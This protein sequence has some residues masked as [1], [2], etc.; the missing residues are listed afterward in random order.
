MEQHT[1]ITKAMSLRPLILISLMGILLIVAQILFVLNFEIPGSRYD[2]LIH[3]AIISIYLLFWIYTFL[4]IRNASKDLEKESDRYMD[5]ILKTQ[6][7]I[8][9]AEVA[10][11]EKIKEVR[12]LITASH[13]FY[14][15]V[16]DMSFDEWWAMLN[17][18]VMT[19]N[20]ERRI[21]NRLFRNNIWT[22]RQLISIPTETLVEKTGLGDTSLNKLRAALRKKCRYLHLEL[23]YLADPDKQVEAEL[24]PL[25]RLTSITDA[26]ECEEESIFS[27]DEH[28]KEVHHQRR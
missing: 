23:L 26:D 17:Q 10:A 9:K 27:N 13:A 5:S 7:E 3:I 11:N 4:F 28:E 19:L 24:L 14:I 12:S 6:A 1:K 2:S 18:K 20:V 25:S 15:N 8:A 16:N 22:I 21:K